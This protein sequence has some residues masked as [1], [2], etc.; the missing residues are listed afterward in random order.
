[1]QPKYLIYALVDPISGQ[2]RYV[3]KS[4]SGLTRP[5]SHGRSWAQA[6]ESHL[7]VHRWIAKLSS[8]ERSYEIETLETLADGSGLAEAEQEWI[9]AARAAGVSLLNLT[10]GGEGASGFKQ[11]A[12]TKE[13]RSQALRGRR[14]SDDTKRLISASKVKRVRDPRKTKCG[15]FRAEA[16]QKGRPVKDD[17]GNQFQSVGD[18]AR[19]YGVN[20]AA[21]RR[22]LQGKNWTSAGRM[23]SYM[24]SV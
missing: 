1:M 15:G 16:P 22:V 6:H 9:S 17:L 8:E 18:A 19:H 10:D 4:S 2:W 14:F 11:S 21:I 7:P 3:G 12:S 24:E 13:K 5:R 20:R 23:F